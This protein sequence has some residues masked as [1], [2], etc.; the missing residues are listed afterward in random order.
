M[1]SRFK[2]KLK[3]IDKPLTQEEFL[4]EHNRLS[5]KRLRATPFLLESFKKDKISL[6]KDDDWSIEKLRRPFIMW[7]TAFSRDRK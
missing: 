3:V 1:I 5:P 4:E 7:L 2:K 6:F